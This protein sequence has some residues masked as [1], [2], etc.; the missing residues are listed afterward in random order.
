MKRNLTAITAVGVLFTS[1]TVVPI[2]STLAESTNNSSTNNSLVNLIAQQSED[3]LLKNLDVTGKL[4]DGG[5]FSGKLSITEFSYDEY[6]NDDGDDRDKDQDDDE[7]EVKQLLASG[8]LTGTAKT[9]DGKTREISQEFE[10]VP[11]T[12]TAESA[13]KQSGSSCDILFL[14]LGPIFL[15]VLGL[16]VD[17]SQVVLDINA[18]QGSGNLLGNLLC[19]LTGLL[20]GGPLARILNLIERINEI[21]G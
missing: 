9:A 20:D 7:K 16:T 17:L 8:V 15:D 1:F 4:E 19:S 14:D 11:A 18:V 3:E 5:T 6:E 2:Q 13:N 10:D 21:L 12:L